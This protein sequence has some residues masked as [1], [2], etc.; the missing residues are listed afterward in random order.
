MFWKK[1]G[2]IISA[3]FN[4]KRKHLRQVNVCGMRACGY[5]H[6]HEDMRAC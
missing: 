2:A 5:A 6:M 1:S 3:L 4:A